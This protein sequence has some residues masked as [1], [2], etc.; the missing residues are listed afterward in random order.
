MNGEPDGKYEPLEIEII[1]R[2]DLGEGR[3]LVITDLNPRTRIS[4][5]QVLG[6]IKDALVAYDGKARRS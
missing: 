2:G 1:V 4:E 6:W 5:Q 3:K